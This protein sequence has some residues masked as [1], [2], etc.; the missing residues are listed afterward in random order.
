MTKQ[1]IDKL[2]LTAAIY[3]CGAV[4]KETPTPRQIKNIF[5]LLILRGHFPICALCN[6]EILKIDDF[7]WDHIV[8][9]SQGG[10]NNLYN[11]QPTHRNCNMNKGCDCTSADIEAVCAES[12]ESQADIAMRKKK[13][14]NIANKVRNSKWIKPWNIDDFER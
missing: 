5:K 1:D 12:G 7:S 6:R 2:L 3:H 10:S 11:L 14:K 8:P 9:H 4:D 13:R